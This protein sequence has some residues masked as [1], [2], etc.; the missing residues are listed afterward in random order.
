MSKADAVDDPA[1]QQDL[2]NDGL[3]STVF[4]L[5]LPVLFQQ[6]LSFGVGFTDTY[7][8]GRISADATAAVGFAAYI[9]WL[10]SLLFGVVSTGTMALVARH[11]GAREF[12]SANRVTSNSI[13]L[14]AALGLLAA[15]GIFA[16]IGAFGSWLKLPGASAEI[17]IR[18]LQI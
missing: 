3:R 18:Y 10:A 12:D 13:L 11:W 1:V 4:F 6:L 5:A 9:G 2:L 8:S 15:I 17:A 14:G 16:G 7:L